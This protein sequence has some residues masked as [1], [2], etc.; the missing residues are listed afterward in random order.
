MEARTSLGRFLRRHREDLTP[1]EAGLSA[2]GRRRTPGLRREEVA[3][4]ANV[5]TTY[6]E[7]LEQARG[8][9]PSAPVLA[10]LAAA[11]KLSADETA[12]L[13]RLAGHTAPGRP[14]DPHEPVDA[15]LAYLL[16]ATERT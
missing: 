16:A 3:A 14:Q 15:G 4:L 2:Q 5:S 13:Y 9:R 11:L 6:Y 1:A 8:P 12:H 7:R 10:A